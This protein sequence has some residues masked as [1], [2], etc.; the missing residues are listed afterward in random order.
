MTTKL[1]EHEQEL[2]ITVPGEVVVK[3]YASA[4]RNIQQVATRPGF[5]AGKMP[6]SLV[7]QFYG[8]EINRK[9]IEK[10]IE[11]SF[12][13]TCK[14]KNL[15]PVS[16]AKTELVGEF[17]PERDFSY[18][19]SFQVKP[20]VIIN[21]FEGLNLEF[22]NFVFGEEDLDAELQGI[23]ESQAIFAAPTTRD[24][25]SESDLVE[26]DSDV[27]IDGEMNTN[28]SHK[29]Y[30]VPLFAENIPADLKAALVGKKVGEIASVNYTMPDDHQDEAI[31]GKV[32][33]MRLS[34]KAFKE[35][36]LPELNDDFAKDLSDK[37]SSLE[38]VRESIKLR[39]TITANRRRDYFNQSAIIKALVEN[40]PVEVPPAMVER[41]AVSLI[42][43]E[44][45]SMDK[46]V[47]K[48]AVANHWQE[49][50]ASVQTRALFKVKTD[51]VL[52]ALIQKLGISASEEEI[53][54]RVHNNK[55]LHR[56]DAQYGIQVEKILEAVKKSAHITTQ[57]EPLY[58][59]GN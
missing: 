35:R 51:L 45:E 16:Q 1:S 26:C 32:C 27:L 5:R 21:N 38:D 34:I 6:A 59:K 14:E 13:Q 4:F 8:S 30:S 29:D 2:T 7:K 41:A 19:A 50:W 3:E 46:A 47:A 20:L 15:I 39:L 58:Q 12:E 49:L 33:E 28:Y 57:D 52:E 9:L 56:E 11:R 44:L 43:R 37:F 22:K 42:N 53:D 36:V 17:H 54:N 55:D 24:S 23:R 40:N 31:K 10:L 25:I 18:R 48:E